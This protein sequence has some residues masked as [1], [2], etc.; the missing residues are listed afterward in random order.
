MTSRHTDP[1]PSPRTSR[2]ARTG[3]VTYGPTLRAAAA[4]AALMT[5][6]GAVWSLGGGIAAL[7]ALV[8]G[9]AAAALAA[10][11]EGE[12][13]DPRPA[14]PPEGPPL[15]AVLDAVDRPV[16]LVEAGR[17]AVLNRAARQ[18]L[19]DHSV[20]EDVRV[21]VRH[22][23][24]ARRLADPAPAD[25]DAPTELIGLGG[26][27]R[28]WE[29]RVAQA[30]RWQVIEL[31]DRTREDAAERARVDFVANASHELRTPLAGVLGFVETLAE[32]AGDDPDT[33]RHFLGIVENEARRMQRLVEDLI[34]LSRVEAERYR[35]PDAPVDL[36]EV[37]DAVATELCDPRVAV[38]RTARAVVGGDR[39]RLSQVLHNLI[40]NA[41]K[42]G[43]PG[44]PVMVSV[45]AAAGTV[46]LTVADRGEGI[47]AEH[48][49]RLTERFYRVD[50]GR[51][52]AVGGTGLGLAIV[53]QVVERHRGRLEIASR[54]GEGTT[55][56]VTLPALPSDAVT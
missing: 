2:R 10:L 56:S 3:G 45:S 38:E 48:L 18:L 55:V 9:V 13:A 54:P 11:G 44:T 24:A 50:A 41:L 36:G 30:G 40:G 15:A 20:G 53:K 19:G 35:L 4:A 7:V 31:A 1:A 26:L 17:A 51:S 42:Y 16:L 6:A 39:A 14:P 46:H 28:R 25:P 21:A 27:D 29:M 23:A 37:A 8:A 32:D 47:A 34:S 43:R 49:P 33:R 12:R 52:R 5:G 22:P